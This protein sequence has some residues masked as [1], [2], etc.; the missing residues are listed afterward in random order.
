MVKKIITESKFKDMSLKLHDFE[1]KQM[2]LRIKRYELMCF[3]T[4]HII[5]KKMIRDKI[6]PFT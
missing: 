2:W 4:D 3:L 6:L 5:T 1:K